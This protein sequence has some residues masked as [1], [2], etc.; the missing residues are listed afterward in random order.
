MGPV[1]SPGIP[2]VGP[3]APGMGPAPAPAAG[4]MGY[5]AAPTY[6]APAS[7][8]ASESTPVWVWLA[9]GGGV[10]AGLMVLVG[11]IV[12]SLV[13][14]SGRDDRPVVTT[15]GDQTP[16]DAPSRPGSSKG[17]NTP[18][19]SAGPNPSVTP[20]KG[21]NPATPGTSANSSG[22]G[23]GEQST[24]PANATLADVIEHV[25]PSVVKIEVF[26]EQGNMLGFGSGFIID[27][28]GW[29]AT[30]YHVVAEAIRAEAIFPDG[31]RYPIKGY[32]ALWP[33]ADLAVLQLERLP[34]QMKVVTLFG[35]Q[36]PKVGSPVFAIGHPHGYEFRVT[37][38]IVNSVT[39]TDRLPEEIRKSLQ[40]EYPSGSSLPNHRWILHDADIEPGNSGGPL[41]NSQGQVIGVNSWIDRRIKGGFAIHVKFLRAMIQQKRLAQVEPLQKYRRDKTRDELFRFAQLFLGAMQ[42]L[43]RTADS[44]D[45]SPTSPDQYEVLQ[46]IAMLATALHA[47]S[48]DKDLDEQTRK[49]FQEGVQQIQQKLSQRRWPL[50]HRNRICRQALNQT[51]RF[52][53]K[54]EGFFCFVQ[55]LRV[56]TVGSVHELTCRVQGTRAVLLVLTDKVPQPNDHL[57]VLGVVMGLR[58]LQAPN[59][60]RELQPVILGGTLLRGVN[61]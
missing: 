29:I 4:A 6:G 43:I 30:N 49:K 15:T 55:V 19:T 51:V 17:P 48:R 56:R 58:V 12:I 60:R 18:S 59:G 8:R 20:T 26:D 31:N 44:F 25:K 42:E 39:N 32:V 34:G 50:N 3:A 21:P 9:V 16:K 38:G 47:L 22:L 41:F 1:A 33:E 10:L 27:R 37:R 13:N 2:N 36:D 61:R 54:R 23:G 5:P 52:G 53:G 35:D 46:N 24:L 7:Q 14:S 57:L 45:W 11:I 40:A 28:Q